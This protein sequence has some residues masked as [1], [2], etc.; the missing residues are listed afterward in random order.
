MLTVNNAK[1]PLTSK[2]IIE[3]ERKHGFELPRD[4]AEFMLRSNGGSPDRKGFLN[5]VDESQFGNLVAFF[6]PLNVGQDLN[7]YRERNEGLLPSHLLIV[8]TDAGGEFIC[9]SVSGA[10]KGKMFVWDTSLEPNFATGE[11]AVLYPII[12]ESFA[13][14]LNK[15]FH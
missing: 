4:Y 5:L 7:Y 12:A 6:M 13:D 3:F 8:A 2:E 1:R 10:T 9:L 15:L 14:F 11:V